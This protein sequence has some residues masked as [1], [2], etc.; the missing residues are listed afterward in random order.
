MDIFA[1]QYNRQRAQRIQDMNAATKHAVKK[2]LQQLVPLNALSDKSFTEISRKIVIEEVRSGKY[3][4]REGDHDN[5]SVYLLNGKIDLIDGRKK[6]TKELESGTDV[7]RYPVANQQPRPL[8]ARAVTKVVIARVDAL[9]LDAYLNWEHNSV[10]EVTEIQADDNED[11]MT[12]ILQSE[13]FSRIP[14]SIIQRLIISMQ[15]YPLCAGDIVIRQGEEGDFFY[16]I[17]K[18]RCAVTRRDTA[19]GKDVLVGEL[20]AGDFF[21]EE[22][23]LMDSTRNATITMLT[24]GLLMRLAKKE[25]VELMQKPL[26]KSISYKQAVEMVEEGAV[27]IDVR[28]EQE[29][30]DNAFEDSVNI[31][32]AELRDQLPELVFN[33]KYVICCDTGH[34]SVTAAFIMSH[35]GF[36]AYVLDGGL[37]AQAC[38]TDMHPYA[39][40]PQE[41]PS[42]GSVEP[43][44]AEIIAFNQN[45]ATDARDSSAVNSGERA[46][47]PAA[48]AL[49]ELEALRSELDGLRQAE[50]LRM[51]AEGRL[52][53]QQGELGRLQEAIDESNLRVSTLQSRLESVE[54]AKQQL[55]DE[56][57][58][59]QKDRDDQLGRLEQEREQ[60]TALVHSLREE[61]AGS[62]EENRQLRARVES[63]EVEHEVE[64]ARLQDEL[65]VSSREFDALRTEF[66]AAK[67]RVARLEE[68]HAT[69]REE[70]S[71]VEENLRAELLDARERTENLQAELA[72]AT[73]HDGSA[74]ARLQEEL[75]T[76]ETLRKE[77][78]DARQRLTELEAEGAA[79]REDKQALT[80]GAK[81]EL[82]ERHAE[83]EHLREE[84]SGSLQHSSELTSR[85]AGE[86]EKSRQYQQQ[87]EELLAREDEDRSGFRRQLEQ[88]QEQLD[89]AFAE[90]QA[91]EQRS[92]SL[93]LDNEALRE[94]NDRLQAEYKKHHELAEQL[95]SGKQAADETVVRLQEE[96]NAERAALQEEVVT[97]RQQAADLQAR[98]E[99]SSEDSG[100]EKLQ[101]QQEMQSLIEAHQEQLEQQGRLLAELQQEHSNKTGALDS[102]TAERDTLQARLDESLQGIESRQRELDELNASVASLKSAADGEVQA[103][104]EQLENERRRSDEAESQLSEHVL[105]FESLSAELTD[106][107]ESNA[108]LLVD[109]DALQKQV[110]ELGN[111]LQQADERSRAR[112]HE[113]QETLKK[114]YEDLSRKNDTEKELQAHIERL[115]KKLEH[116]EET[117]QAA[118]HDER[119]SVEN[120]RNE[121]NAERRARAEERAQMAARQR[122][123]KEQLI[124]VAS[125]HEEALV[126]R[127]GALVQARDAELEEERIRLD[128]IIALQQQTEQQL[129]QLQEELRR[130]HEETATAVRRE[131]ESNAADLEL[132]RQQKADT[133]AAIDQIETQLKQLTQE[134]D[135]ALTEQQSLREQLNALR[136]E[137]EVARGL[138]NAERQGLAEDPVRLIAELKETRRNIGIA[139]HLR[140]EAEV[141]RDQAIAQLE[142]LRRGTG[143]NAATESRMPVDIDTARPASAQQPGVKSDTGETL[144][145]A[146]ATSS[147]HGSSGV[148]G[149]K[150][151][152]G[153]LGKA[154]MIGFGITSLAA[155]ALWYMHGMENPQAPGPGRAMVAPAVPAVTVTD[156]RDRQSTVV[157]KTPVSEVARP[158][159]GTRVAPIKPSRQATATARVAAPENPVTPEVAPVR[160][161]RDRLSGGGTGPMMVELPAA[162]YTM[163]SAGNSLNFDERPEHP[164]HLSAFAIGK[165]EVSFAEYDDF[166]RATGRHVPKDEGWGRGDRPVINVSWKDARAYAQWLTEQTGHRYRLPSES[167]WEFAARSGTTTMYW[168]EGLMK[169]NPA[170]CFDCGSK[171]DG[172][173]TAPVGSFRA[174]RFGIFDTAGNVQEW[175]EDCYHPNYMGAPADGGAWQTP[176]C[177][178]R[179]VRGGSYT[180]PLDSLKSAK[181]ARY[182]QDTRLDNLGFRVV[183][184]D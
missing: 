164:V 76:S 35:K 161:F 102:L 183:R 106:Q 41:S 55:Q 181:R 37:D 78:A 184:A 120:I 6:V 53:E 73:Q 93:Q 65:A 162:D 115:R 150:T 31:P 1:W 57:A 98:L 130:A 121:L 5:Q 49:A 40:A 160:V 79:L 153:W 96:W 101:L 42:A 15:P 34:R 136:A 169:T 137:A 152:R 11:W 155:L 97:V 18:G 147:A 100:R 151:V 127:D 105:R 12:R 112:D 113:N 145:N 99:Q 167:E 163:G 7:S 22:S 133:D 89:A 156:A 43:Q 90:K 45:P 30:E 172:S 129:A 38:R 27:W 139:V 179:V 108:G 143:A 134:R 50:Q 174:N 180:S 141:Q 171:W 110:E 60:S 51:E 87:I 119:E 157:G 4:F 21:G 64:V 62:A 168:W 122:E 166:A 23:L 82:A 103:L 58:A 59:L 148:T 146:G 91:L 16:S 175:T 118:R 159:P 61:G 29:Y 48:E 54:S 176:A 19:D 116:S 32:L 68:D 52:V 74:E 77:L 85:L 109:I 28:S 140:A 66:S 107:K 3:L 8:S 142:E 81:S 47:P 177:T 125:Q 2:T 132:A 131:R 75:H 154:M 46:N 165:Y 24:D 92:D 17:H 25:F 20:S 128:Q 94:A 173:S 149:D 95:T 36:E 10:P 56:L 83:L 126:A 158:E 123:L 170:N 138:V 69:F 71:R 80:D 182:H 86:E 14:P 135:G 13:S 84:L 111:G 124:S 144:V 72:R 33:A 26:V 88:L 63:V 178:E 67:E 44:S 70:H 9:M 104:R 117:L 114:L 39:A